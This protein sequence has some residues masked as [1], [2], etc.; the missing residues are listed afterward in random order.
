MRELL[1]YVDQQYRPAD[2]QGTDSLAEQITKVHPLQ[3]FSPRNFALGSYA[4]EWLAR[5]AAVGNFMEL[6]LGPEEPEAVVEGAF[7]G[8]ARA[9]ELIDLT[10][11]EGEHPRMGATD[12]CP[13]VPVKGVT[14]DDCVELAQKLGERVGKGLGELAK[15]FR[16]RV[17]AGQALLHEQ[18]VL[19]LDEPMSGLDPNQ[20]SEIRALI[21]EI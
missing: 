5:E 19:M 14:M 16:Q 21:R 1:D 3:P 4:A 13:F 17:V 6:P 9:S 8:I 18:A 15:G 11:H 10:R 2:G 20:A 12:V 7:R